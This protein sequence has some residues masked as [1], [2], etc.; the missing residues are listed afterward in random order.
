M[1]SH[2][3]ERARDLFWKVLNSFSTMPGDVESLQILE[4]A[5]SEW[6]TAGR[7][8][9]AGYAMSRAATVVCEERERMQGYINEAFQDFQKCI[10]TAPLYSFE[11]ITALAKWIIL[12]RQR[13]WHSADAGSKQV[14]R[15]LSSDLA[16]QLVE[17]YRSSSHAE[18]FL[19]KGFTLT[20]DLEERWE[21]SF[22]NY[23]VFDGQETWMGNSITLTL[24]S[25]FQVLI[26]LA[27]YEGAQAVI[28]CCP[29]A[30][31][32]PGLQGWMYAVQGFLRPNEAPEKFAE[33]ANVFASDTHPS[34]MEKVMERGGTWSS[35]NTDLW[36]RYFNSRA[37]LAMTIREPERAKELIKMAASTLEGT[38]SGWVDE[39][40]SLYRGLVRLLAWFVGGE[41]ILNAEETR[42]IFSREIRFFHNIENP[43]V[44]QFVYLLTEAFEGLQ[45]TPRLEITSGRLSKALE[46]LARIPLVGA[47][48]T[49]ALHPSIGKSA[50][51]TFLGPIRTGIHRALESIKDEIQ[52]QKIIL[53]LTQSSIPAYAQRRHGPIEY[54]KDVVVLIEKEGRQILKMY[55]VKCGD[56]IKPKWGAIR[57]E[58]EE[59]FLVPLSNLH[60]SGE[61]DSREVIL[62]CNGHAN[63]F[64]EPVM[65][66]W[67]K[68]E[69]RAHGRDYSFMHL[70]GLVKW[71]VEGKLVNEFEAVL[72]ELAIDFPLG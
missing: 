3:I 15:Q 1:S 61:V 54:G 44:V 27:D 10:E 72:R 52:L 6:R 42:E 11:R 69:K 40:V 23:E 49:N 16:Q 65:E 56:I 30:F 35:I 9:S 34:T 5:A 63:P 38:E 29:S 22:P 39:S 20:T 58:L 19:V 2:K 41:Q 37:M 62:V 45:T 24:P 8:F 68:E 26:R 13:T 43:D 53:R 28:E 31:S 14:L 67:F 12:L 59:A 66:N 50:L 64:V 55:Q 60:I 46:A 7:H 21:P 51:D 32:S 4:L 18:N 48:I 57:S 17:G 71:I 33:A 47:E 36:A 70:D 25:A